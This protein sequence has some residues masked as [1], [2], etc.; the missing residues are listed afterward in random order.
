[1]ASRGRV[2]ITLLPETLS[3]VPPMLR[4]AAARQI[5]VSVLAPALPFRLT[6]RS[7]TVD[8]SG[9]QLDATGSNLTLK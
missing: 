1:S 8:A 6:I 5:D 2:R 3:G 7:V 9:L 4:A